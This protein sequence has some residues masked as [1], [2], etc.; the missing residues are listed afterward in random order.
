[1]ALSAC[2]VSEP[3]KSSPITVDSVSIEEAGGFLC[4]ANPVQNYI[5]QNATSELGQE[6]INISGATIL[7]W[8]PP[9]T[10]ITKDFRE[11]RINIY[12]DDALLITQISC[13]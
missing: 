1:M 4:D 13:S 7:R 3:P 6:I 12:Y 10:A 8:I 9:R 2:T 5:K 11:D